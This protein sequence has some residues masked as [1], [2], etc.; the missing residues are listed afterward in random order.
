MKRIFLSLGLAFLVSLSAFS[1]PGAALRFDGQNDFV[2]LPPI[3]T[4]T[5]D[6]AIE[7]WMRNDTNLMTQQVFDF[8]SGPNYMRFTTNNGAGKPRFSINNGK[9]IKKLKKCHNLI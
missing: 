2:S 3:L 7:F 5:N 6:F 1:Q 8:F 9:K 4:G